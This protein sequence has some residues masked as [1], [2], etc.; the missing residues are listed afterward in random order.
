MKLKGEGETVIVRKTRVRRS[1][2]QCGAHATRKQTF[3]LENARNNPASSAYGGDDVSWCED[4]HEYLCDDCTPDVPRGHKTCSQ[5]LVG[6]RFA[7][8]FLEW[9]EE[10]ITKDAEAA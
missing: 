9:I 3:L 7:H 1:C 8:M 6:D 2:D 10:E 4:A 5:F